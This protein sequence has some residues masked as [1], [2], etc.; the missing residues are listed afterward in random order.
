MNELITAEVINTAIITF[1]AIVGAIFTYLGIRAGI[2]NSKSRRA[3][4]SEAGEVSEETVVR[5]E[6][7]PA[8]FVR[9]VLEDNAAKRDEMKLMREDFERR[10]GEVTAEFE[11]KLSEAQKASDRKLADALRLQDEEHTRLLDAVARYLVKLF[12]SWGMTPIMPQP[13]DSDRPIL[14]HILPRT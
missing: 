9:D 7:N 12:K 6:N 11:R 13:D 2:A 8:Q 5:Y 10:L 14:Q 3:K 1:G 4:A